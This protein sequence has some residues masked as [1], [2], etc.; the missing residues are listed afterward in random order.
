M[1]KNQRRLIIADKISGLEAVIFVVSVCVHGIERCNARVKFKFP[2]WAFSLSAGSNYGTEWINNHGYGK[3][4]RRVLRSIRRPAGLDYF[5]RLK[6]QMIKEERILENKAQTLRKKLGCFSDV[7]LVRQYE[8]FVKGYS[9]SWGLGAVTFLYEGIISEKVMRSLSS[10]YPQI[11]DH[12]PELLKSSYRSFM[13]LSER[14]LIR[15]K[16]EKNPIRRQRLLQKYTNKFFYLRASYGQAPL[17][18]QKFISQQLRLSSNQAR[19]KKTFPTKIDLTSEEKR[20]LELLK[21]SEA[22]RDKRKQVNQIGSYLMFRFL[23][24]VASRRG[25]ATE[26]ATRTFWFEYRDLIFKTAEILPI[27]K[28]R[29]Q[30]DMIFVTSQSFYLDYSA[31]RE[32]TTPIAV[33]R[34]IKGTP[35]AGGIYRGRVRKIF[36]SQDFIKFKSG[37]ILVTAMTRP[38]FLLIMKKAGAIITDEGSL[39][40]HAAIIARELKKPCIVGTRNATRLLKDGDLVEIN[41]DQGIVKIIK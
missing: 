12:L 24:E 23:E 6:A 37:E 35:A 39:T 2:F 17:V 16:R 14:A 40:S 21:I 33:A 38:E 27:L 29:K 10:R 3:V 36:V 32:R 8:S 41:A 25:I 5:R 28:K 1:I 11:M 4:T 9:S 20:T 19:S 31:L 7:E 26:L 13:F 30:A 15:I 18:N 34:E 22:I